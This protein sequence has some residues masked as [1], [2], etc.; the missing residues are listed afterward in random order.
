M[1]CHGALVMRVLTC[2]RALMHPYLVAAAMAQR[3]SE[4]LRL[5]TLERIAGFQLHLEQQLRIMLE[6]P[7]ITSVHHN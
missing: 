3:K 1:V 2:R 4:L 5:Q 7:D 6:N